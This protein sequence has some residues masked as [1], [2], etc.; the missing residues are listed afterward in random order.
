MYKLYHFSYVYLIV[1]LI[2]NCG[3]F[4][5]LTDNVLT[6]ARIDECGFEGSVCS[7][8]CSH[9]Q[10]FNVSDENSMYNSNDNPGESFESLSNMEKLNDFCQCTNISHLDCLAEENAEVCS[11]FCYDRL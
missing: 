7:V 1:P 2:G 8:F 6:A 4:E 9:P 5:S 10:L 3:R 11:Q